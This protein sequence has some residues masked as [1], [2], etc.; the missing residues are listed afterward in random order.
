VLKVIWAT[1]F[2]NIMLDAGAGHDT[3]ELSNVLAL[4]NLFALLGDGDDTLNVMNLF[5]PTGV[6]RIDGGAGYDR[7]TKSGSY[8]TARLEQTG[9]EVINGRRQDLN[10]NLSP[11]IKTASL[12]TAI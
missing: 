4:D 10:L 5:Q 7:L 12:R 9:W 2:D 11:A 3:M 8:P 6:A 1:A